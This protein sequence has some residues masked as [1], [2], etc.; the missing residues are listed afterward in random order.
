MATN[1]DKAVYPATADVRGQPGAP[2]ALEIE[3]EVELDEGE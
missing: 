2:A 1:V 3:L